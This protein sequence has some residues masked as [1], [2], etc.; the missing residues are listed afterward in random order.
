[1]SL[2]SG[3]LG[4]VFS[5]LVLFAPAT[6]QEDASKKS[7]GFG[8]GHRYGL[9]ASPE[10]V[11]GA[12]R[13]GSYN[14]LNYFDDVDD[15]ALSG[16]WDD[17]EL[18][19]R[20]GQLVALAKAIRELDADVLALQEVESLEALIRF[21]DEHLADLGYEHVASLDAGYYRGVEQSVLSRVPITAAQ[22]WPALST[23]DVV[24][25]GEGF[26]PVPEDPEL[27]FQRSPLMVDLKTEEG[28][29]FTLIVVH[30][31]SGGLAHAYRRE[32]EGL[33]LLEIVADRLESDPAS[34]L[35]VL[36]DF[37]AKSEYKSMQL[38]LE[39]GL[40][41]AMAH[42]VFDSSHPDAPH[43]VTHESG[44]IIDYILMNDGALGEMVPESGFVL[45]TFYPG[46]SNHY[47]WRKDDAPEAH[48]SDHYPIAV[49]LI[50]RESEV[51]VPAAPA[52]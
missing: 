7:A 31:K 32:A 17:A 52:Q 37:N 25:V 3:Q 1:M 43:W 28:Y 49:D 35:I 19:S 34:N 21:R 27:A 6:A 47:D 9:R 41:D 13:I 40:T 4:V 38:L 18:A 20:P 36:G 30:L 2:I 5:S 51:S 45:G 44:R 8:P 22:N 10:A 11:D 16:K 33:K 39:G 23:A 15:P 24:R 26:Q 12:I 29:A 50:P 48:A 46:D 14:V 42:R